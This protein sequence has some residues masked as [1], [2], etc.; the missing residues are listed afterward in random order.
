MRAFDCLRDKTP[1]EPL[2]LGVGLGVL[3]A[4]QSLHHPEKLAR[5]VVND[6]KK[7]REDLLPSITC[8]TEHELLNA[9]R[10]LRL[11]VE[12]PMTAAPMVPLGCPPCGEHLTRAS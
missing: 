8:R 2:L 5:V 11:G 1:Q 6:G 3:Q 7:R 9:L 12:I 10:H 4:S